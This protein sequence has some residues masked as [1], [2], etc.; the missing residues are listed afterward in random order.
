[1]RLFPAADSNSLFVHDPKPFR[2]RFNS[3]ER[4]QARGDL[5]DVLLI[6]S[7]KPKYD[8]PEQISGRIRSHVSKI[9]IERD[10]APAFGPAYGDYLFIG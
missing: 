10:Q 9:Q 7:L 4:D 8:Q 6:L 5:K 3:Q 1:M 2:Q